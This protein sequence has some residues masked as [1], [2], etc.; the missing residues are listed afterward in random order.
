[1]FKD[2]PLTG[3]FL[4][5][6]FV[7]SKSF[8]S[9]YW[10]VISWADGNKKVLRM[11]GIWSDPRQVIPSVLF[12]FLSLFCVLYLGDEWDVA[13]SPTCKYLGCKMT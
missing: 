12:S 3:I 5:I 1:M 10:E 2:I 8:L 9:L 11:F 4:F 6:F 7:F 13:I